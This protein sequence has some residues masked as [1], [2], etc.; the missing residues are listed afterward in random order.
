MTTHLHRYLNLYRGLP[1]AIWVLA[2]AI[3]INRCGTM[4]LPFLALYL[5]QILS[6]PIQTT[7]II[8]AGYGVGAMLGSFLGGW[9]S[10]RWGTTR[11]QVGTLLIAAICLLL[12]QQIQ[13][14]WLFAGMLFFLGIA[15]DGYRPANTTAVTLHSPPKIRSRAFAINRL[16][17]NGG[18]AIGNSVG[19]ILAGISYGLLFQVDAWTCVAAALV[20]L[21][22]FRG[23]RETPR[24]QAAAQLLPARIFQDRSLVLILGVLLMSIF[25]LM[26]C[27]STFPIFLKE[28]YGLNEFAYGQLMALNCVIIIFFELPVVHY[29]QNRSPVLGVSVGC[30]LSG[31]CFALLPF[32]EGFAWAALV[33]VILTIGEMMTASILFTMISH[34]APAHAVGKT[35][36]LV[37]GSFSIMFMIAPPISTWIYATWG[38]NTLWY[39]MGAIGVATALLARRIPTSKPA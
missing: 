23:P 12:L 1:T 35:M 25:G 22:Y 31:S 39:V 16:G 2:L 27:F 34:R 26:Q 6:V 9:M 3:F 4:V 15:G 30:L 28:V 11:V 36:A 7:G 29:F 21:A 38:P 8:I 32:Y 10:D 33:V 20:I 24:P 14:P 18:M 5:T 13:S 17:L 19:G 37:S